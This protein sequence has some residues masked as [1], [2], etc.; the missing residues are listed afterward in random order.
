MS[1][2]NDVVLGLV[3]RYTLREGLVPYLRNNEEGIQ[4]YEKL[5]GFPL[6]REVFAGG[7]D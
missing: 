1:Q 6:L 4:R 2:W 7:L 3:K 5:L